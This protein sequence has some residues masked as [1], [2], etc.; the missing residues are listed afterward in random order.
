MREHYVSDK[1]VCGN[2]TGITLWL[3]IFNILLPVFLL[4]LRFVCYIF[5]IK[6]TF[7]WFPLVVCGACFL[8]ASFVMC[9]STDYRELHFLQKRTLTGHP[10]IEGKVQHWYF[11]DPIGKT[12]NEI[13]KI[14]DKRFS[15]N[16]YLKKGRIRLAIGL[17]I[18]LVIII[19]ACF[20]NKLLLN[21]LVTYPIMILF[22]FL[23]YAP[24]ADLYLNTLYPK[25]SFIG[26]IE[27][28]D[29]ICPKCGALCDPEATK[30][31]DDKSS[32]WGSTYTTTVT[33]KYTDGWNTLYVERD[34][35]RSA[36]N[37]SRSWKENHYCTKCKHSFAKSQGYTYT[38]RH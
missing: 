25:A 13:Q 4:L 36:T 20:I 6:T 22:T 12:Q 11:C 29:C 27:W 3:V 5:K 31:S 8:Y 7:H 33:D 16:N 24:S 23:Y 32:T 26:A 17:S 15:E 21:A 19:V 35:L 28:Q 10:S 14:L 34:E 30:K 37:H 1:K 2:H 9:A 38:E 18:G